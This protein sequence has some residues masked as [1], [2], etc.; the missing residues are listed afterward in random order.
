MLP[1]RDVAPIHPDFGKQHLLDEALEDRL[2]Q[3]GCGGQAMPVRQGESVG[4]VGKLEAIAAEILLAIALTLHQLPLVRRL[5]RQIGQMT[6]MANL[7]TIK[8]GRCIVVWQ[9]FTPWQADSGMT[10]W[11]EFSC[12]INL[13]L[14]VQPCQQKYF[15]SILTQITSVTAAVPS[16]CRGVSRSSRTRDGMRWTRVALLTRGAWLADGQVVWS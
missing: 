16:P 15:V 3:S 10:I 2:E 14:P 13:M 5:T 11:K 6:H 1:P 7:Q 12:G 8:T 9:R 4:R